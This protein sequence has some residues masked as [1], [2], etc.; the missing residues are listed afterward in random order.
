MY[1]IGFQHDVPQFN[2]EQAV[3]C[4]YVC[5][6]VLYFNSCAAAGMKA[7]DLIKSLIKY[8]YSALLAEGKIGP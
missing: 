4:A 7:E 6:T 5:K 1:S 3:L 2:A 8:Q